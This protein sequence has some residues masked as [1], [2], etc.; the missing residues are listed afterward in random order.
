MKNLFS[1]DPSTT[2]VMWEPLSK[3][4]H[5][6]LECLHVNS[7]DIHYMGRVAYDAALEFWKSILPLEY[8]DVSIRTE[9]GS[10]NFPHF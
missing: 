3:D 9:T 8:N 5:N 10:K 1:S 2:N 7:T 4:L 6:Y